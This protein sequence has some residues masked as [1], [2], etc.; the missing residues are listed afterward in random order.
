MLEAGVAPRVAPTRHATRIHR[1]VSAR[2]LRISFPLPE[3]ALGALAPW[4]EWLA[5]WRGAL[6]LARA[7]V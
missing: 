7:C 4:A 3:K 5:H 2:L 1:S 6:D